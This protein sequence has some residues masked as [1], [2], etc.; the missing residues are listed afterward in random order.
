[1]STNIR[2][3]PLCQLSEVISA[4]FTHLTAEHSCVYVSDF[5][6]IKL[7]QS[8]LWARFLDRLL[9][10]IIL[11]VREYTIQTQTQ[12]LTHTHTNT[13][14][15]THTTHMHLNTHTHLN[16]HL[17]THTYANKQRQSDTNYVIKVT[18]K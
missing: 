9:V 17:N 4:L 3:T 18:N 5:P 12:T 11:Y 8:T 16:I 1:M 13:H 6:V 2:Q 7:P 10:I 15:Q 14:T